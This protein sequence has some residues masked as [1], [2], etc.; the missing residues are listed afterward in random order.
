[1][2][3]FAESEQEAPMDARLPRIGLFANRHVAAGEELRY[4]YDMEPGQV[5]D[6]DG[7]SRSL[8]CRC[9]SQACR[10]RIY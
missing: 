7:A 3:V 10:G 5:L 1:M 4:D 9:G 8:A 6:I 2:F